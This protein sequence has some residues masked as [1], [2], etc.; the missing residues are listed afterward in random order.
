MTMGCLYNQ[1]LAIAVLLLG[2]I[3]AFTIWFFRRGRGRM[4]IVPADDD[5]RK[6]EWRLVLFIF[7]E[8]LYCLSTLKTG[9]SYNHQFDILSL[10]CYYYWVQVFFFQTTVCLGYTFHRD[11]QRMFLL[12]CCVPV[13]IVFEVAGTFIHHDLLSP[14][15]PAY[16]AAMVFIYMIYMMYVI[17]SS[18]I[19][20]ER[21]YG[22]T[23]GR[24]VVRVFRVWM[25][26]LAVLLPVHFFTRQDGTILVIPV[27]VLL[28][29]WLTA[30]YVRTYRR[31]ETTDMG[32]E[33]DDAVVREKI[34]RWLNRLPSPLQNSSLS[35]DMVAQQMDIDRQWLSDYIYVSQRSTFSAWLSD[36]RV[37][38]CR[39]R[40][41][42][43]DDTLSEIAYQCGYADLPTMSKA[44]K[45]KFAI[46]PS[47]YRNHHSLAQQ[48]L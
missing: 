8:V 30:V 48:R 35:M 6:R 23:Q 37:R 3:A 46:S 40:L 2:A 31:V 15:A 26:A 7:L 36:L 28:T 9:D 39:R 41:L 22:A 33:Q 10:T 29:A 45:R 1:L 44:F 14:Q 25:I 11:G 5:G 34:D 13:F 42:E 24:G 21:I 20:H 47:Y 19:R 38:E 12:N 16:L 18:F 43:T 17:H 27:L 32:R 4:T